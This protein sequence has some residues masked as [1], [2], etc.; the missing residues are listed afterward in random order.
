MKSM[1]CAA[2]YFFS[3]SSSHLVW[4]AAGD[5][6]VGRD[7]EGDVVGVERD[8]G[9]VA[10]DEG[11]DARQ[12]L[13]VGAVVREGPAG[14][15]AAVAVGRVPGLHVVVAVGGHPRHG[16]GDRLGLGEELVPHA[17]VEAGV[18]TPALAGRVAVRDVT[19][20]Q[21]E[22]R[23]LAEE[24]AVVGERV[25]AD[26]LVTEGR[27]GEGPLVRG[28]G[29]E[30]AEGAQQVG[31]G[32]VEALV[33]DAVVVRPARAQVGQLGVDVVLG[34]VAARADT[35]RCEEGADLASI[36]RERSQG[37]APTRMNGF[38]TATGTC[39]ETVISVRGSVP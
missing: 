7:L 27:E 39:Q 36:F 32:R 33:A 20:V 22:G 14:L 10:V 16:L 28:G 23:V 24:Q 5:A 19:G 11:V 37:W 1:S 4:G 3:R 35:G 21:V 2:R 9:R 31:F 17:R 29:G 18:V 8:D 34:V 30:G 15:L 13:L 26:A 6:Q 12:V 25:V 38:L